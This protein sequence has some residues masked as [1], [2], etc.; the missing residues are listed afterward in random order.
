MQ[1][2]AR[3][4]HIVV[5]RSGFASDAGALSIEGLRPVT[6]PDRVRSAPVARAQS[7][8]PR[9]S[10]LA[11]VFGLAL[12]IAGAASLYTWLE[13]NVRASIPTPRAIDVHAALIDAT[14]ITVTITGGTERL[15]QETTVSDVQRNLTLWRRMNLA[16]WNNVPAPLRDGA[17]GNMFARYGHLLMNPR[18]WDAMHAR[19]WD[20][21]PQPMRTVAY[22]QMVAYWS[23][24]YDVGDRYGL[25]ARLVADT[26][27][28]I[29]MSE[30]W[31]DHRAVFV[32]RDGSRDIGLAGASDFA[33]KRVRQLHE[34]GLVDVSVAD[35]DYYNPW[36][37]TR[38]VA[39]WMM[40]L[41]DEA[42]GNLD[43][44]VRAYNR[45][46]A[47][48]SDAMGTEYLGTVH[49]RLTR[50]IQNKSAPSGW[51]YVW[52]TARDLERQEWPWMS[53][54]D[55]VPS[56]SSQQNSA[57]TRGESFGGG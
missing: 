23:G 28:A 39:I 43:L 42:A 10:V 47:N 6:N 24:Y 5:K 56:R 45:G 2:T 26:L 52:R 29:I 30:S 36:I 12:A 32:N 9:R 57:A 46:I 15:D 50:F 40:L 20:L 33:R 16:D 27:A 8:S 25:S 38:F 13:H 34:V 3:T 18:H 14:P 21:V 54:S 48:A 4:H 31:F 19:D 49:N 55:V 44:A 17:L 41:L 35:V 11:I 7:G 53:H 51:D 1:Q 22:R 37:A